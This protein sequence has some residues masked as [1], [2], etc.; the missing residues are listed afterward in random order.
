MLKKKLSPPYVPVLKDDTD[1]AHFDLE[2]VKT[3]ID[4]TLEEQPSNQTAKTDY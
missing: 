4:M 1:T 3:N 2:E